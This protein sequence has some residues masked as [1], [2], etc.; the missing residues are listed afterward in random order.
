MADAPE[1][2]AYYEQGSDDAIIVTAADIL[3]DYYPYWSA[4]MLARGGRSPLI[5]PDNCIE[6]FCVAHWAFPI[7]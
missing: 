6:D 1:R 2:F 5:T 3:R 4:R 7:R